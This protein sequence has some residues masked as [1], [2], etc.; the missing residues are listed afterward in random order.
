[1]KNCYQPEGLSLYLFVKWLD[2]SQDDIY[3]LNRLLKS[4]QEIVRLLKYFGNI[5]QNIYFSIQ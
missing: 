2:I 5:C 3:I 1:M 4:Y